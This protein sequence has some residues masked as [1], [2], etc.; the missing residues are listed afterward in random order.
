MRGLYYDMV[1]SVRAC[2]RACCAELGGATRWSKQ[3]LSKP[4][5]RVV[6]RCMQ[7]IR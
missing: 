6:A 5:E 4:E 7:E 1:L 2:V 3:V